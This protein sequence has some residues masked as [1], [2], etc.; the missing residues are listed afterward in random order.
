MMHVPLTEAGRGTRSRVAWITC[1]LFLAWP[2]TSF[3][4]EKEEGEDS[5][6]AELSELGDADYP[7]LVP[8]GEEGELYGAEPIGTRALLTAGLHY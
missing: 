8:A 4:G 3:P 1:A 6:D 5:L 7:D 2:V